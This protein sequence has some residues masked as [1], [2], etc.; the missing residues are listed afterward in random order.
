MRSIPFVILSLTLTYSYG[1]VSNSKSQAVEY[2][3]DAVKT[4]K[5]SHDFINYGI[6]CAKA[7]EEGKP[8]PPP[9]FLD[10]NENKLLDKVIESTAQSLAQ[11]NQAPKIDLPSIA[12]IDYVEDLSV[13]STA[14]AIMLQ[15]IDT[16]DKLQEKWGVYHVQ[17]QSANGYV[18]ELKKM[19]RTLEGILEKLYGETGGGLTELS[20]IF[21]FEAIKIKT[22]TTPQ[23]NQIQ[24]SLKEALKNVDEQQSVF[25]KDRNLIYANMQLLLSN[26]KTTLQDSLEYASNQQTLY[27]GKAK[28]WNAKK[29][30]LEKK[31]NNQQ[32]KL[33]KLA[34]QREELQQLKKRMQDY[35]SDALD[36]E[37]Q[38]K[39]KKKEISELRFCP[40]NYSWTEC[41][42]HGNKNT[43]TLT[44]QNLESDIKKLDRKRVE[45]DDF[46]RDNTPIYTAKAKN[47]NN[48]VDIVRADWD[49]LLKKKEEM[50]KESEEVLS[51]FLRYSL[52]INRYEELGS[53][54]SKQWERYNELR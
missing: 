23:L 2:V 16:L 43:F 37:Q 6:A 36:Y 38:A 7:Q 50:D 47:Y 32:T 15:R 3:K 9:S 49:L 33:D 20:N 8:L 46:V 17:L 26:Q 22:R 4:L 12:T 35:R 31:M 29:I 39:S 48:T 11:F 44:K 10:G 45:A 28:L 1:L 18:K 13:R 42:H 25:K 40:N 41:T 5:K 19:V 24:T 30:L 52:L 51:E 53:E 21:G 54:N 34:E 27:E 14:H